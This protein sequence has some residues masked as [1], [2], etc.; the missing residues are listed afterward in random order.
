MVKWGVLG[1]ANIAETRTIPGMKRASNCELY[2]IAGRDEEKVRRFKKNFGFSKAY[3]G[4]EQLLDD[5]KVQAVYI[6]L[7]NHLHKEWVI[8]A[9]KKGKHVLCEKPLALNAA[10]AKEMF[11]AAKANGVCLMEAFAYLHSVYIDFLKADVQTRIIGDLNYIETAFI[12]QGYTDNYRLYKE[13]GGGALY[14]LGCYCTSLILTL[15][16]SDP[17]DVKAV[18]E[19]N[20]H[21]ADVYTSV[22]LKFKN[23]AR[24]SFQVGMIFDPATQARKDRLYI[25]G[26]RGFITSDVEYNQMGMLNYTVDSQGLKIDRTVYVEQI[27]GLEVAQF[28]HCIENN[29]KPRVTKEFSI[30]NAALM[31]RILDE[32]GY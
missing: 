2:A 23:G 13:K 28:G 22:I 12:T 7:P 16:G 4:Y 9:L 8:K 32:I 1:T 19:F 26:T 25:C 27:Y 31:D 15:T 11:K 18:A 24:A 6:P 20:S 14:D 10:D 29:E 30:K 5:P 17:V 21:G 3:V